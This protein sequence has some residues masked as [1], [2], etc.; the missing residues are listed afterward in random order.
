MRTFRFTEEQADILRD[1]VS[2]EL[3]ADHE[4]PAFE[5]ALDGL[6]AVLDQ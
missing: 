4:D 5:T 3:D 2:L 6:L 1:L